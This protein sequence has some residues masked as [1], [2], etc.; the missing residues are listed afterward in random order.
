M[1]ETY[2]I[3]LTGLSASDAS[4]VSTH[5][6]QSG[7]AVIATADV[8]EALERLQKETVDLVLLQAASHDGSVHVLEEVAGLYPS[9]PIVLVC[10]R[11][12]EGL[13][14]D[15]WR[16]GA[17]DILFLPLTSQ[18]LD[19]CM[20]HSTRKIRAPEIEKD[21]PAVARFFYIDDRGKECWADLHPPRFR[22][23]RL[24]DN[25]LILSQM[26]VS[27]SHAEVL[28][29]NGEYLLHDLGSKMGTYLNG[30]R[31]EQAR[32]TDGDRVQLGGSHGICLTFH[33]GDILQSLFSSSDAKMDFGLSMRGFGDIGKLF[34]A[35]RALSSIPVLDDLLAL[36]VD[37]AIEFTGAERGFIMLKEQNAKLSFRC[38]RNNQRRPL[39]GS[40][41][42]TSQRVPQDVFKTGKPV[43]IKNLDFG[44]G[45]EDHN[46]TRQLGLRSIS[47]VPL[48]YVTV[49]DSVY[50]S[51]AGFSEIIGVL[52]VDSAN[53]GGGLSSTRIDALETL[54]S[55]AAMAIYNARLY[56]DS[57]DKRRMDEQLTIAREIQ[58]ALLPK[59]NRELEFVRA[60]SQSLP[61]Y[62]IGGDYFDYFDLDGGHFGFALGDVA[63]KGM[64]AALLASLIQ[65]LF[66]AQTFLG[67]PLPAILGNVNRQL[68]QRGTGSRFVTF[69]FGI[70]DSDGN[71]T[72]INA[73]HN[74]PFLLG[75]D[76]SMRE[77]TTGGMV[78]GLFAGEKYEAET[79]K[80]QK[81]DH[82]VLFTDGVIEALNTAGEEFGM[83]RLTALLR[84]NA[85]STTPQILARLQDT[86]LSFSA[87]AP[88]HDDITMMVLG[89]RESR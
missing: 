62:E 16:A 82:L 42:Q 33:T 18:S 57:Q 53:V 47:C 27:R 83:E 59:P 76:G 52:Y 12:A 29:Q 14:L 66:S 31:V 43:V 69:F 63:G 77:L 40:C 9:L 7:H 8:A 79:I 60:C 24:S 89:F 67:A 10:P 25:N 38:A 22:L 41:F 46:I 61:C 32:L 55:E 87:G 88:Q 44:D 15:A 45:A 74:P 78:L 20:L 13:V 37:T 30:V 21:K 11:T 75:R 73:G 36:V 70:L 56:K 5:F 81:D 80:L 3:L 23:G 71:C 51:T 49:H 34:A 39:D 17:A 68:V 35:F 4:F 72:Y 50:S 84:A 1:I 85:Q 54:A 2:S 6:S 19:A 28:I 65:G 26:G 58:Q 64:S 86:V 48:R